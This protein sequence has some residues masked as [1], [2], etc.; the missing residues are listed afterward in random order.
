MLDSVGLRRQY[1]SQAHVGA[2]TLTLTID[3][4]VNHRSNERGQWP[5]TLGPLCAVT[6]RSALSSWGLSPAQKDAIMYDA[7]TVVLPLAPV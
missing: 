6:P 7:H 4:L 1:G 5:P 3:Q 2:L